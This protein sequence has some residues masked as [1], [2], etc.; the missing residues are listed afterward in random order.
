VA[1]SLELPS[2]LRSNFG[3]KNDAANVKNVRRRRIPVV[4]ESYNRSNS[5]I[6]EITAQLRRPHHFYVRAADSPV[7]HLKPNKN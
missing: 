2:Q 6:M 4:Q 7:E 5:P 1:N 3:S